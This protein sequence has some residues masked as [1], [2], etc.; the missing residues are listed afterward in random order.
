MD[1]KVEVVGLRE[2]RTALK[3]VDSDLPKQLRVI[4]VTAAQ[5]VARDARGRASS[6]GGALGKAADSI[7]AGA[8]Q[9][10]GYVKIG[11][12]RY[13]FALGGE[14]GSIQF[15]QFK[16]WRGS[17]AD[18]G[19]ALYPAKRAKTPLIVESYGQMI[20]RLARRAFPD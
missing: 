2:F 14:F 13:P 12:S 3:A 9:R 6:V 11:G 18:A 7:K 4:N 15:K 17:G 1:G 19:Y 10:G 16:P 5:L 20:D 8:T